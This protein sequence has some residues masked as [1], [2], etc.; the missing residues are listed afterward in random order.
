MD[1][2]WFR[3]TMG[4]IVVLNSGAIAWLAT[5]AI[6]NQRTLAALLAKVDT[7]VTVLENRPHV[8]PIIY[9]K[10]TTEMTAALTALTVKIEDTNRH[11]EHALEGMQR[12]ISSIESKLDELVRELLV[13]DRP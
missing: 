4:I 7:R 1:G 13:P 8:D 12:E 10:V 5:M 6:S 2:E 11:R 9:T 3:W